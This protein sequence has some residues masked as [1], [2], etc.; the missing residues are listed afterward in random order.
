MI[1]KLFL[2]LV[3]L[4]AAY[5]VMAQNLKGIVT[6]SKQRP[7]KGISVWKKNTTESTKTDKMGVFVFSHILPED[8]LVLG[9]S[10]REEAI[11]PVQD[12]TEIVVK[13][14]KRHF[15]LLDGKSEYKKEYQRT[16]RVN[17]SSNVLTREQIAKLSAN[18]IYDI[19]K[20]SI[21]GVTVSDGANGQQVSI[22]GGNSFDL[23]I[24]PLFVVDG[25]QYESSA[26]VDS[27]ISVNDIERI[28][29]QKDGAAYGMKGANGVIIITTMKR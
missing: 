29:V 21:S 1:K 10:K 6:N 20:G 5:P 27:Y 7:L 12:L 22:R 9:V 25:T 17:T 11:I 3:I 14:E 16:F 26:E 19:L 18:S 28:E 8:T 23:N 4:F 15:I 13:L 24:E 2:V